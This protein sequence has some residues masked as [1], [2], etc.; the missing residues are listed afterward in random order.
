MRRSCVEARRLW[1]GSVEESVVL[2]GAG[3][4]EVEAELGKA[5]LK[6]C[7]IGEGEFEFDL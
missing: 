4:V 6:G 3:S 2:E 5:G 7:G 1:F